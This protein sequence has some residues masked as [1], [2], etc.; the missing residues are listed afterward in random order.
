MTVGAIILATVIAAHDGDTLTAQPTDG[1][2]ALTIRLWHADA[3]ELDQAPY[4]EQA[5][6]RLRALALGKP[7]RCTDKGK[8]QYRRTVALCY[9]E[10]DEGLLDPARLLVAEGLAVPYPD[11]SGG[12]YRAELCDAVRHRR[13]AWAEAPAIPETWRAC[14]PAATETR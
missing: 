13:G 5:R 3:Y 1:G 8:D 4:G 7:I 10:A 9:V 2:P 6:D 14:K 12:T 11:P